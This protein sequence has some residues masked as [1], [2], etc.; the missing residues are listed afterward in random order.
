MKAIKL[1]LLG[2]SLF[3][4]LPLGA[5]VFD[6]PRSLAVFCVVRVLKV[7]VPPTFGYATD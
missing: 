7:K 6:K 4:I 3:S 2:V 1:I 5:Q